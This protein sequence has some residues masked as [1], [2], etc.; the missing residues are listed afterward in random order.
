M[1]GMLCQWSFMPGLVMIWFILGIDEMVGLDGRS[2]RGK[3][4][5]S[6]VN[7]EDSVEK[8]P[9]SGLVELNRSPM[10]LFDAAGLRIAP[11]EIELAAGCQRELCLAALGKRGP[12][13]EVGGGQTA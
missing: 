13:R 3:T 5:I 12:I 7:K 11:F 6:L 10:D 8:P 4:Q 2:I 9:V 1:P